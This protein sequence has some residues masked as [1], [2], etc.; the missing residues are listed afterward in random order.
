MQWWCWTR[1]RGGIVLTLDPAIGG[2]AKGGV[3]VEGGK[4]VAI[5][6]ALDVEDAATIDPAGM[7][8]MP[9]LID[10]HRHVWPATPPGSRT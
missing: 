8:V 10:A 9:G 5:G 1:I 3:L 6:A 4:I 7:I 2:F